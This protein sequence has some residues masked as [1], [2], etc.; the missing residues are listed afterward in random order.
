MSFNDL[1]KRREIIMQ[2][3]LHP[4]YKQEILKPDVSYYS[5]QCV[6]ELHIKW[7]W[8]DNKLMDIKWFGLGCAIFQSSS[9]IFVSLLIGKTKKEILNITIEY[10]KMINQNKKFNEKILKELVIFQNVKLQLNRLNCANM[11][12]QLILKNKFINSQN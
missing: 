12:S 1:T 2:H 5:T 8:K 6:D 10:E 4:I 9:D 7:I 3:Y 11:I